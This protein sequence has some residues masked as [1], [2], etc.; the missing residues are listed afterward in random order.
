VASVQ[1]P[2]YAPTAASNPY[3]VGCPTSDQLLAVAYLPGLPVAARLTGWPH[4]H[5]QGVT[6]V[7]SPA[8]GTGP[9]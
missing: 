7:A 4:P 8:D 9:C 1:Q 3:G 6:V 5:A 2:S